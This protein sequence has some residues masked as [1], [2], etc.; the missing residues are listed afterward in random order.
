LGYIG[1]DSRF[2]R[3]VTVEASII[4]QKKVFKCLKFSPNPRA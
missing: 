1:F 3:S 2:P 4:Q